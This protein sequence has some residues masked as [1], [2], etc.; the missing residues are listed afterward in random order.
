VVR[1]GT[2]Y[3]KPGRVV[4]TVF[5][6]DGLERRKPLV[7]IHCEGGVELLVMTHPEVSVRREGPEG[8]YA[9]F[10]RLLDGGDDDLL[11]VHSAS[12]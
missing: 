7:V 12:G 1:G 8:E 9:F 5:E 3:R 4:D 2:H 10:D 6:S 11:S